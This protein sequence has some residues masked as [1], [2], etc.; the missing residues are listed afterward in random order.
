MA[1][2]ATARQSDVDADSV[3]LSVEGD[4][5]SYLPGKITFAAK[6]GKSVDLN[7]LR[8]DLQETRLGKRTSSKVVYLEITATGKVVEAGKELK[9]N[10]GGTTEQFVLGENPKD[11]PK[12]DEKT[13][14]ARLREAVAKGKK[15]V[16]VT[17]RVQG[18]SGTWPTVLKELAAEQ[19]KEPDKRKT[20]LLYVTDFEVAK[21]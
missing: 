3:K 6:K 21:E 5:G 17:G 7:R 8:A 12:K 4:S 20:P 13:A 10:V 11:K 15:V 9:L 14:L 19:A 1:R 2:D 18:W 16:S